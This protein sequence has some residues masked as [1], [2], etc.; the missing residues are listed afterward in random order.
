MVIKTNRRNFIRNTG[1]IAFIGSTIPHLTHAKHH[2][3]PRFTLGLSQYSL[4]ALLRD[5]SLD[6]L[7]FPQFTV[8]QFG[9]RAIDLWEGGL[10]KDKLDDSKY[11]ST[12]RKR[13]EQA[14][15][16]LFLLMSGALDV[17]VKKRE[18]STAKISASFDRAVQLG[19]PMV[20]VFLKAPGTDPQAGL[21]VSVEALKP[22]ADEA[23]K[24]NLTIAIEP[25]ASTLSQKGAFLAEV[26]TKLNHPAL[27]L[28]PDF[29]KLKDNVYK[30][31]QAMLPHTVTVSCKMH[32]FDK[33]GNQPDFNYP[34]LMKMIKGSKYKGILAI[35]WEGSALEP[36]PGVK[37]SKKLIEKSLAAA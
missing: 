3:D 37:A 36:I 27:K 7:D 16:D 2:H 15:T 24:K 14:G 1:K 23:A 32:S 19:A 31:T 12:M 8:D 34:R 21:K 11:L 10:P 22:L 35:E 20:R 9:I 18:A 30:G 26:A 28:M 17:S 33:E 13:A 25:G 5:G 4:R 29:G 6:A